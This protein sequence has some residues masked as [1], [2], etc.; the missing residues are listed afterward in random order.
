MKCHWIWGNISFWF[1]K[2]Q[3]I[4][5]RLFG[6]QEST[7]THTHAH[8]EHSIRFKRY[9]LFHG[10]SLVPFLAFSRAC[11]SRLLSSPS[12]SSPN[13]NDGYI[14]CAS[15]NCDLLLRFF[16][17][18]VLSS[19]SSYLRIFISE[20]NGAVAGMCSALFELVQRCCIKFH[21]RLAWMACEWH[22]E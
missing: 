1:S 12:F 3:L 13:R 16:F 7:H 5:Q 22:R 17:L 8:N 9:Q 19:S 2:R 14:W 10:I 6:G 21:K 4:N 20:Y 15:F 11:F 18:R